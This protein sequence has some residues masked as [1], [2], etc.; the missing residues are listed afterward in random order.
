[1]ESDKYDLES[2]DDSSRRPPRI[3]IFLEG[4]HLLGHNVKHQGETRQRAY[5]P[6][7]HS[8]KREVVMQHIQ[9]PHGARPTLFQKQVDVMN[10]TMMN[11]RSMVVKWVFIYV[12]GHF[13]SIHLSTLHVCN[14]RASRHHLLSY[15]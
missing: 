6:R 5:F 4:G 12:C 3:K 11:Q 14:L 10:A 1:M 8:I 15:P 7:K 13:Q 9:M 2:Y